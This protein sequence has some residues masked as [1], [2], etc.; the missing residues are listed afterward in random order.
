MDTTSYYAIGLTVLFAVM[1]GAMA[2]VFKVCAEFLDAVGLEKRA[3]PT[4]RRSALKIG[5]WRSAANFHRSDKPGYV[6]MQA[7]A[8]RAMTGALYEHAC[9][10][11]SAIVYVP[12]ALHDALLAEFTFMIDGK[13][14]ANIETPEAKP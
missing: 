7:V 2:A 10:D 1:C 9:D 3:H 11:K 14:H 5:E 6:L 8:F 13:G 4:I 12:V